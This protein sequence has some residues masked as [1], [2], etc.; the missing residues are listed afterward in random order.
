MFHWTISFKMSF[1]AVARTLKS[2]VIASPCDPRVFVR[3]RWAL[4][5][6]AVR[7]LVEK[8]NFLCAF[9]GVGG[10]AYH[11]ILNVFTQV[12]SNGEKL[13]VALACVVVIVVGVAP[14]TTF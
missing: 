5:A 9:C 2:A 11:V 1:R 12:L 14:T 13:R 6:T 8:T 3:T 4:L 10:K 7:V